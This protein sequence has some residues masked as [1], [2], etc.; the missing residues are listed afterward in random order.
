MPSESDDDVNIGQT[1]Q[2]LVR[3]E[4]TA[5][6]LESRLD[7]LD[8]QLLELERVLRDSNIP[9][10]LFSMDDEALKERFDAAN[11]DK[12]ARDDGGGDTERKQE[13]SE[14]QVNLNGTEE[15]K[16]DG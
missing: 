15:Q 2:D 3:A 6:E 13:A 14:D 10:E 8:V 5:S 11:A 12:E 9:P 1:Y 16:K 7:N 4:Q